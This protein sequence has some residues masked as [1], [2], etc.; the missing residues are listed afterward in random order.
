MC[1]HTLPSI[2][3]R[4]R[5][6][7]CAFLIFVNQLNVTTE[8]VNN[9]IYQPAYVITEKLNV[10]ICGGGS[11]GTLFESNQLSYSERTP[12]SAAPATGFGI[13]ADTRFVSATSYHLRKGSHA[14]GASIPFEGL[15]RF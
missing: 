7:A 12:K 6:A 11:I 1:A 15:T 14:I 10:I 8:L 9:I 5:T 13:I 3:T 4:L 2:L